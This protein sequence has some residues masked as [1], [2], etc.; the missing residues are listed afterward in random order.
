[1][2]LVFMGDDDFRVGRSIQSSSSLKV[3]QYII[4]AIVLLS[5]FFVIYMVHFSY[6]DYFISPH[7]NRFIVKGY[8]EYYPYPYHADEWAHLASA[9]Y[10][11][12]EGKIAN[13]NPYLQT[14]RHFNLESGFD[15]FLAEFFLV[16]SLDPMVFYQ[17]LPAFFMML[18][19]ASL[20]FF[21]YT[22]T[23]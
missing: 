6:D 13:V 12:S 5:G 16:T 17:F 8:N 4:L 3:W 7:D 22:I 18:T 14:S 11:I 15:G 21:M 20:F 23:K 9:E 10:I 19:M 2:S 1:M